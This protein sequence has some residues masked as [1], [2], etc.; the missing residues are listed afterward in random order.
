MSYKSVGGPPPRVPPLGVTPKQTPIACCPITACSPCPP[1]LP[2]L[3]TAPRPIAALTVR[4]QLGEYRLEVHDRAELPQL[5]HMMDRDRMTQMESQIAINQNLQMQAQ[6]MNQHMMNQQFVASSMM[7]I[8]FSQQMMMIPVTGVELIQ[9]LPSSSTL[10]PQS[11]MDSRSR[12]RGRRR[13]SHRSRARS[14]RSEPRSY[15][16]RTPRR[17]SRVGKNLQ[18]NVH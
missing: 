15:R 5:T 17:S 9:S 7:Q 4:G 2:P 11:T 8:P 14:R 10:G 1:P 13:H 18:L 16:S 6:F 3:P 12:S